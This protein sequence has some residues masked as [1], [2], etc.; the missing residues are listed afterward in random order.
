M[1]TTA[2]AT[3]ILEVA[4][5]VDFTHSFSVLMETEEIYKK[6]PTKCPHYCKKISLPLSLC[7]C[8]SLSLSLSLS[9]SPLFEAVSLFL[10]LSLPP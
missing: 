9:P 4:Q 2:L 8:L 7:R 3:T 10:P 1:T 6:Y 5:F